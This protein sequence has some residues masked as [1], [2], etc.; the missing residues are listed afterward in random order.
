M[1][2]ALKWVLVANYQNNF[3]PRKGLIDSFLR[4]HHIEHYG[5]KEI[6]GDASFR[7]YYRIFLNDK[8]N[9]ILMDAPPKLEDVEPFI[10]VDEI[11]RHNHFVAPKIFAADQEN[12]F[13]LL[14]DFGDISYSKA[15]HD[16]EGNE[17][18]V[19]EAELYQKAGNVLVN[20]HKI[21]LPHNI[22]AYDE[23]LLMREV[24]LFVDWYLPYIAKK[25]ISETEIAAFKKAWSDLFEQ[26]SKDKVLVLRDYHADNL[27]VVGDKVGLLDFQDAV[28][29]SRA[30]DLVSLLED[31]RRDVSQAT[32]R[33]TLTYYLQN[34]NCK[35]EQF[36][37]DYQILS[38]QRNI[39]I[40]GIFSRLAIRDKKENYLNL[41]PKMF[42]YVTIRLRD[43]IFDD[44]RD[45]LTNLI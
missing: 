33:A 6:A 38:L 4:K 25:P 11:L 7:K 44:I 3:M 2:C 15:L 14:E 36:L 42:G 13:L 24:M 41:L 23:T 17:L 12:G 21:D 18:A 30:Y 16:L 26:L 20:L 9:L 45:L 34:S 37:T 28:L 35:E 39:K 10:K 40:I 22:A 43:S 27:F 19:K 8:N 32:V 29:G 1:L 5:I 31:A